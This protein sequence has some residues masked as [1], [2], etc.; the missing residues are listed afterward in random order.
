MKKTKVV[1]ALA[2]AVLLVGASVMGTLAYLTSTTD[3]V[4]NTFT[5]GDNV[6]ITLDEADVTGLGALEYEEDSTTLKKRVTANTYKLMPGF[7]YVKDPTVHVKGEYCYVYIT[8]DGD[9][10][11][12]E[13]TAKADSEYV[14]VAKQIENN[15]WKKVE[16]YTN[17]YVY[18][19]G[20]DSKTAVTKDTDLVIFR[21]FTVDENVSY[22][23]LNKM[24]DE[25]I[26]INAYAV[27]KD[28]FTDMGV[29]DTF[30]EAFT[31]TKAVKNTTP[32][33]DAGDG[34]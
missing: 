19:T 12:V 25:N 10:S 7:T 22:D 32:A 4:K 34:E 13:P 31:N 2:C 3:E 6:V 21:S 15:G 11:S 20:T 28:G 24:D 9:I 17:L 33:P 30:E 14:S 16:G 18:A 1:M 29:A 26:V 23:T 5:V 8:V 27:Q